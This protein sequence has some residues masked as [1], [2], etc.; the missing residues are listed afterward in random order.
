MSYALVCSSTANP[1]AVIAEL[2]GELD[3]RPDGHGGLVRKGLFVDVLVHDGTYTSVD[4]KLL[5]AEPNFK[6][7]FDPDDTVEDEEQEVQYWRNISDLMRVCVRFLDRHQLNGF[8]TVDNNRILLQR[9]DGR[10]TLN[11]DYANWSVIEPHKVL[12]VPFEMA[13]LAW[14]GSRGGRPDRSAT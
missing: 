7:M 9:W 2:M 10:V 8:L 6:I 12:G 4:A 14:P 1:D 11:E 3:M 5:G 13:P